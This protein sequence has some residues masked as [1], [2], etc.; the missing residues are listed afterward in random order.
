MNLFFLVHAIYL[1]IVWG[2]VAVIVAT[3]V[4]CGCSCA[5]DFARTPTDTQV[6]SLQLDLLRRTFEGGSIRADEEDDPEPL[7]DP[8]LSGAPD[9][10][11]DEFRNSSPSA[12]RGL[13]RC[14]TS[15]NIV[16][17]IKFPWVSDLILV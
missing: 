7:D 13:I 16:A 4:S 10:A 6:Y 8:E 2:F 14:S 1:A 15:E 9:S 11:T 3:I 17:S 12:N 5:A